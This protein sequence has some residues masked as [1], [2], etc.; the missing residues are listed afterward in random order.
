L[1]DRLDS[2]TIKSLASQQLI[3]L[4]QPED[5]GEVIDCKCNFLFF[6]SH[7]FI[8]QASEKKKYNFFKV[9]GTVTF[10]AVCRGSTE[11]VHPHA[12]ARSA[13]LMRFISKVDGG[14]YRPSV[15]IGVEDECRGIDPGFLRGWRNLCEIFHH[16]E[17]FRDAAFV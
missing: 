13:I 16:R 2:V 1:V 5:G 3:L 9:G 11:Q 17:L 6:V 15:P 12:D 14:T 8:A 10:T 7:I 4:F